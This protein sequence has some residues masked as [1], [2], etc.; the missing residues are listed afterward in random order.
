MQTYTPVSIQLSSRDAHVLR[1]LVATT[2]VPAHHDEAPR[3]ALSQLVADATTYQEVPPRRDI[4][5][6]YDRVTVA[7]LDGADPG[8][9]TFEVVTPI[10]SPA[11]N[12]RVSVLAPLGMGVLGRNV[13][14]TVTVALPSS[15]QRYR[16]VALSKSGSGA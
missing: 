9:L 2:G 14:D 6:L 3:K 13:G 4:V 7:P 5:A 1:S 12:E 10:D 8:L 16:I 11:V 15:H